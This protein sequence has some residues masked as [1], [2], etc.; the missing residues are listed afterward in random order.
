MKY[1]LPLFA[2]VV[3]AGFT[4]VAVAGELVV[5]R[6]NQVSAERE[7][8]KMVQELRTLSAKGDKNN[9]KKVEALFGPTVKSFTRSLDPFQPWHRLD[10]L[11]GKYLQGVADVMVEQG[12]PIGAETNHD[13]RIDAMQYLAT[14]V[15]ADGTFGTL[16]EVPGA[17]CTPAA[18]RIDHKAAQAFARKFELDA[19]SLRFYPDDIVLLKRPEGTKGKVVP[20]YSLI[21]F[22]YDP[23]T[24]EGWGYYESAGGIKGYLKDRDDTLGLSQNHV[25]FSKVKG[26]YRVSAILG[27]GL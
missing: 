10:D 7:L 4:S 24:P 23:K 14:Y 20:A 3:A 5:T 1:T 12:E 2:A 18:Y 16:P 15:L 11:H 25:C 8:L 6:S 21:M 22:D 17:V 26:Q 27:Y 9:I 13:Y 19:Y